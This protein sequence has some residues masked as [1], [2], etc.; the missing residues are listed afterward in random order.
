MAGVVLAV[1]VVAALIINTVATNRLLDRYD[2]L[3]RQV[4]AVATRYGATPPPHCPR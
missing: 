4:C 2:Q 1:I 3:H